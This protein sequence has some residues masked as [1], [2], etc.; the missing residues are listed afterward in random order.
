MDIQEL[1]KE[2]RDTMLTTGHVMPMM[3]LQLEKTYVFVAIDVISDT[4]SIPVQCGILARLG[5]ERCREFPD[6]KVMA[7][8]FYAEA[9]HLTGPKPIELQ[10]RP[11]R[12]SEKREVIMKQWS[13]IYHHALFARNDH[14]TSLYHAQLWET[15]KHCAPDTAK[16]VQI[17]QETMRKCETYKLQYASDASFVAECDTTIEGNKEMLEWIES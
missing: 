13:E 7:V 6:E 11:V 17:L 15:V 3:H 5:L 1:A 14:P 16:L 12:S 10:M 2:A 9:W 4:Q 8:G